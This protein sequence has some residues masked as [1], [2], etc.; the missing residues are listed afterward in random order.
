MKA[1]EGLE[2]DQP[3][4]EEVD[5]KLYGQIQNFISKLKKLLSVDEPFNFIV[6][7]KIIELLFKLKMCEFTLEIGINGEKLSSLNSDKCLPQT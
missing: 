4:R 1:I 5:N 2:L 3:T 6:S 7:Y